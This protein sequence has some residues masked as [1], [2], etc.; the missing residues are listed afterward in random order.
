MGNLLRAD[1]FRLWRSKSFWACMV[2]QI[3]CGLFFSILIYVQS[4]IDS[5]ILPDWNFFSGLTFL[6]V[7]S[8]FFCG[9]FIG[10]EYSDGTM[11][12]KLVVG[13]RRWEIYLSHLITCTVASFLIH[14]GYLLPYCVVILSSSLTMQADIPTILVFLLVSG[15]LTIALTS[16]Y[17]MLVI[18]NQNR[19][20]STSICLVLS[21]L[22][23]FLG[24][25]LQGRLN[26]PKT[27]VWTQYDQE[28]LQLVEKVM[29]NPSY[30]DGIQREVYEVLYD[31]CPGGQAIQCAAWDAPNLPRLPVYSAAL[32]GVT[33]GAGLWLFRR[34][35]LK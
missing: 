33:T 22:M 18:L 12:N 4:S 13:Y 5:N 14:M 1:F 35:D 32:T 17:T 19:S 25:F 34:K 23:L 3:V 20:I 6:C 21:F 24:S 29:E 26:H 8:A 15:M 10:T 2:F 16:L 31:V 9:L 7:L 27:C 11:R 30:V 28:T